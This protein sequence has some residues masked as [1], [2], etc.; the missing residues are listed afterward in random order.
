MPWGT[1]P[2][3]PLPPTPRFTNPREEEEKEK[4]KED[5][6]AL[7]VSD[8]RTLYLVNIFIANTARFLNRFS[9]ICEDKLAHVHRRILR[10]A[11]TLLLLEAKL[12]SIDDV[13]EFEKCGDLEAVTSLDQSTV[14]SP[15]SL[16]SSPNPPCGSGDPLSVFVSV[17]QKTSVSSLKSSEGL[18]V[19]PS[20]ESIPLSHVSMSVDD[21]KLSKFLRMLHFGVPEQAVKMQMNIEGM[22][23]AIVNQFGR[24]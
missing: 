11:A 19:Q 4:E 23:P 14:Q 20:T 5:A 13:G 15:L 2:P 12:R 17:Q 10:L 3:P 1:P 24:K 22:D 16:E 7:S 18:D 8:Q 21:P 6:A 9:A